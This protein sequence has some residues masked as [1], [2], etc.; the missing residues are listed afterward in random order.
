[1]PTTQ[2]KILTPEIKACVE[3]RI[4]ECLDLAAAIWPD[5]TT[6]FQDAVTV[7]YDVKNH[8]GGIAISGGPDDWTIRLNP[9]LCFENVERFMK[10]TVG[11]EVAHL[12]TRVVYGSTKQVEDP[13]TGKKVTKKI[14]SHGAEWRS[15]MVKFDLEPTT[16]HTY[17]CSS[18]ELKKK[19]RTK[20]GAALTVSQLD[21][22]VRRLEQGVKRLPVELR[23]QFGR[24]CLELAEIGE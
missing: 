18:I 17:D 8:V 12:V 1:M 5:H 19:Q 13:K 9:V 15:V 7:R 11:H 10:Q 23:A 6:K 20:R 2:T 4:R 16:C 24:H 14:R 3:K 22:L 21:D